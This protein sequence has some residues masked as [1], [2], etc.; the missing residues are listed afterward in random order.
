MAN[1]DALWDFLPTTGDA[2]QPIFHW[3][4][5]SGFV[6][7]NVP[8]MHL[9]WDLAPFTPLEELSKQHLSDQTLFTAIN[10]TFPEHVGLLPDGW[11]M[12]VT[13]RSPRR[14]LPYEQTTPNVGMLHLN[15]GGGSKEA[16]WNKD[17]S[18][19]KKFPKTWVRR[20]CRLCRN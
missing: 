19:V 14:Y 12:T 17:K 9:L 7:L 4:K 15:G 18:F 11:D 8:K 6:L 3:G 5:C 10:A 2:P 13:G 16:Y 1:L 20:T